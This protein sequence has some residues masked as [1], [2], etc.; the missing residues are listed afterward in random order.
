[1]FDDGVLTQDNDGHFRVIQDPKEQQY[2][3]EQIAHA[4]KLK[5]ANAQKR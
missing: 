4:S 3:R 1:M 5:S 2:L